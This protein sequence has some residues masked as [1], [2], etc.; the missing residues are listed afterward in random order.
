MA[1]RRELI[2]E[3]VI[4]GARLGRHILHDERSRDYPAEQASSVTDVDHGSTGLPLDQGNVGSCTAEATCGA[5]NSE[6][7]IGQLP[8][9]MAGHVFTQDNAYSLY[10]KETADEGQPWPPDDPGGS[11]L[12]VCKAAAEMGWITSYTHAFG[13]EHALAALVL[14]PNIWGVG[15]YAGFDSPDPATGLVTISGD[16]RGGHEI[17]AV[18]IKLGEQLVGFI[19]SWGSWGLNGTGK[20]YIGFGDCERLLDEQGDVTVPLP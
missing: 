5:L 10:R 15:W 11:G 12:A 9:S 19:N 7:N 14:R 4:P 20:F 6:P 3:Q 1:E 13:F 17:V 16:I 18:E 2:P 8:E